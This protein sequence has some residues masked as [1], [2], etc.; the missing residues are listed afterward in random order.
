MTT[1]ADFL[2]QLRGLI[3]TVEQPDGS[4]YAPPITPWYAS[5]VH[6]QTF[7]RAAWCAETQ[8]YSL[9]HAALTSFVY[10]YCPFIE[11][12]AKVGKLGMSWTRTP[13]AAALVLFDFAGK[14]YATHV[15]AVETVNA[16]GSFMTIEGN[17]GNKC[18]RMHRDMKYVR[19]FA[20]LPLDGAPA[21][22]PPAGGT[23]TGG[24]PVLRLNSRG[25]SVKQIQTICNAA[26]CNVG[27]PDGIFGPTTQ[28]GVRCLQGKLNVTIDGEVGPNT[29]AAIDAFMKWL[30]SQPATPTAGGITVDGDFGAATIRKLQSVVGV[31]QDGDFGPNTKK[32]TQRHLGVSADGIFGPNSIRALQRKVGS[33]VDGVWGTGTTSALQ[34]ALNNGTF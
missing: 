14:G 13:T 15:G 25:E 33:S 29:Y 12:D 10:A 31:A 3:G 5:L 26:G 27:A 8:T 6:D 30:A 19:G 21:V 2:N 9:H 18:Q 7:A 17:I 32:A 16:D 28:A 24:R 4:N 34:R 22:L 1:K 20:I 11:R 23:S